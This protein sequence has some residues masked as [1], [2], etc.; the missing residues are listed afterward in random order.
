MY[1]I[2]GTIRY[3][4]NYLYLLRSLHSVTFAYHS[5]PA[6]AN[7]RFATLRSSLFHYVHLAAEALYTKL[8]YLYRRKGKPS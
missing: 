8:F 5:A 3:K 4:V 6:L 7:A 2:E 1:T